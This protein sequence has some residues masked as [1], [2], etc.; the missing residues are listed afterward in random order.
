M[1][2]DVARDLI[3]EFI[4]NYDYEGAKSLLER[5]LRPDLRSQMDYTPLHLAVEKRFASMVEL[6]LRHGADP[7]APGLNLSLTPL[8]L[9]ADIYS[10][11]ALRNHGAQLE[12]YN[13]SGNPPLHHLCLQGKVE[14]TVALLSC[15]AAIDS[16][17]A[18]GQAPPYLAMLA[19]ENSLILL[20]VFKLTGYSYQGLDN[21]YTPLH[22]CVAHLKYDLIP[23]L[24]GEGADIRAHDDQGLTVTDYLSS[25]KKNPAAGPDLE[26]TRQA[27]GL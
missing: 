6:L 13:L 19:P 3:F 21:S 25:M 23:W 10:A 26:K 2:F 22:H 17:N 11:L 14:G 20:A 5:G 18:H 1:S 9:A 16:L 7:S 27:L 8:H 12:A 15:G 24:L 4:D